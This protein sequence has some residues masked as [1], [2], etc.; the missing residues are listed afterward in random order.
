MADQ[1]DESDESS[2]AE[3]DA[4][5]SELS[6][7]DAAG[8]IAHADDD[9]TH[10]D[11]FYEGGLQ[12]LFREGTTGGGD[13]GAQL[14][15]PPTVYSDARMVCYYSTCPVEPS[16]VRQYSH[17]PGEP[18]DDILCPAEPADTSGSSGSDD[19]GRGAPCEFMDDEAVESDD[20]DEV[21]AREAHA[22][23]RL[24]RKTARFNRD[25][26]WLVRDKAYQRGP[27]VRALHTASGD[28][29]KALQSLDFRWRNGSCIK[30]SRSVTPPDE[31]G[32]VVSGIGDTALK[33]VSPGR[34]S[35]RSCAATDSQPNGGRLADQ[36]SPD[37]VQTDDN[38]PV[39]GEFTGVE[40]CSAARV[41]PDVDSTSGAVLT[42]S[43]STVCTVSPALEQSVVDAPDA[44]SVHDES[45]VA[46]D[47]IVPFFDT[48][49]GSLS[50]DRPSSDDSRDSGDQR[51]AD[52]EIFHSWTTNGG[53]AGPGSGFGSDA[54]DLG[55]GRGS[56]SGSDADGSGPSCA[57]CIDRDEPVSCSGA[58][59]EGISCDRPSSAGSVRGDFISVRH[60]LELV[61]RG[62]STEISLA[63]VTF[64]IWRVMLTGG[65]GSA[66]TL[67]VQHLPAVLEAAGF[68]VF[69]TH[70][71]ATH[72]LQ[73]TTIDPADTVR[74]QSA[75]LQYQLQSEDAALDRAADAICAWPRESSRRYVG[76]I[77][78][79][80]RGGGDGK[81]FSTDAA[82]QFTLR[83]AGATEADIL[84]RY[85]QIIH[86][87]T[88][89]PSM[90]PT[91]VNHDG[92][93]ANAVRM[94]GPAE[95]MRICQLIADG[96]Y[97]RNAHWVDVP[98]Y[99]NLT[100]KL[101]HVVRAIALVRPRRFGFQ[102]GMAEE[103]VHR[104]WHI[105]CATN[106][107]S[108]PGTVTTAAAA[109]VTARAAVMAHAT[110]GCAQ[111]I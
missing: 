60:A 10:D 48:P 40:V 87:R 88:P 44:V 23:A 38:T 94:H 68:L 66:K 91:V 101:A 93:P 19:E 81:Y 1:S 70:E 77:L 69:S 61:N 43:V 55:S 89:D 102:Y 105:F 9:G 36:E 75:L 45:D 108:G 3:T 50:S 35:K 15:P 98:A 107:A 49:A 95:S 41:T 25:V 76:V 82:W 84:Q 96:V 39:S 24:A 30:R 56:G 29:T 67:A 42:G 73:F 100:Y 59:T 80:D 110:T 57:P 65:P 27:A 63:Q 37:A 17:F 85:T 92:T 2:C 32:S 5:D 79:T 16:L 111:H 99:A 103:L 26:D 71:A 62:G 46:W 11:I 97:R 72:L 109:A 8:L 74:F 4:C 83:Q 34:V 104:Y 12:A 58:P 21:A 20:S 53:Y 106:A 78:L 51:I 64:S 33:P 90:F 28:V 18:A 54:D 13:E 6:Q 14:A 31:S 22:A 7:G 52:D 47:E 86:M